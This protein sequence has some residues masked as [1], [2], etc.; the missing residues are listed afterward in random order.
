[1]IVVLNK[2]RS[3]R[4]TMNSDVNGLNLSSQTDNRKHINGY[5]INT[6]EL[7]Y[8]NSIANPVFQWGVSVS[9]LHDE[10]QVRYM[11]EGIFSEVQLKKYAFIGFH[12][13]Q[14]LKQK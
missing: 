14:V 10:M 13:V 8:R 7:Q 1:M 5:S 2:V 9:D 3:Q 4:F 6:T 11:L 12:Q